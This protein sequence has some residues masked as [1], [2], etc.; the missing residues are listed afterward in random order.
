MPTVS[1]RLSGAL[2]DLGYMILAASPRLRPLY[3]RWASPRYR[4]LAASYGG[5]AED[6]PVYL[7]PLRVLLQQ[8]ESAPDRIVEVGAGTGAATAVLVERYPRATV[9]VVDASPQM[10]Q[11]ITGSSR[12]V[13]HRVVGDA[14]AL[15]LC[16]HSADLALVH[17]APFD[18]DELIR[19]TRPSGAVV[20]VLSSARWIPSAV[21]ARLLRGR[22][23]RG[24]ACVLE[25]T[26][27]TGVVWVFQRDA[28]RPAAQS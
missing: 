1:R 11:Q 16:A 15:P 25:R 28:G 9:V 2:T 4:D 23:L 5:L 7:R 21:R 19:A 8:L 26:I 22:G 10:L 27:G 17:N 24:W 20:I 18:L 6:D 14:F 13:V 3:R 12:A